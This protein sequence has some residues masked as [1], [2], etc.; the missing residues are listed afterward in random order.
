MDGRELLKLLMAKR[1]YNPNSLASALRNRSLQSQ[2]QRYIDGATKNPRQST[3]E[4]LASFFGVGIEAFYQPRIAQEVAERLQLIPTSQRAGTQ[5][6]EPAYLHQTT[7]CPAPSPLRRGHKLR[8][9][10]M[11]LVQATEG[12]DE[13]T[14]RAV[15]TLL[16]DIIVNP[17]NAATT[18]SRIEALLELPGNAPQQRYTASL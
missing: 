5:E 8:D 12:H 14:R 10:I 9:N 17:T 16:A 13:A 2:V 3:L 7:A 4:P 1:G 6:P 18:A 15:A 11:G